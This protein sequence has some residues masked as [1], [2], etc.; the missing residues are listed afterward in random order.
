[1]WSRATQ[2]NSIVTE[3]GCGGDAMMTMVTILTAVKT[4]TG[5]NGDDE[6]DGSGKQIELRVSRQV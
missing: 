4:I 6:D 3:P 1:M 2:E 5:A